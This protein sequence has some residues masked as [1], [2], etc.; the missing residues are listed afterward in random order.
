VS[1][2]FPQCNA[3]GMSVCLGGRFCRMDVWLVLGF[4]WCKCVRSFGR[5]HTTL[6]TPVLV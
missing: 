6:E 4:E 5:D 3:V 1:E 2:S